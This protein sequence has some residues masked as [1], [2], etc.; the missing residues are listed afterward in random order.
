VLRTG[1]TEVTTVIDETSSGQ[2]TIGVDRVLPQAPL[3]VD[4]EGTLVQIFFAV[5]GSS[6]ST[7]DL[8]LG[9]NCL[10]DSQEPPQPQTNVQCVG[11][12]VVLR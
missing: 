11:G 1:G 9:A 12:T 10:L 2:L 3:D 7:S 8:A 6:A 5:A 4:G